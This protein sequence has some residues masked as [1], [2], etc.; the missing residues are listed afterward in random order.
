[1]EALVSIN[2]VSGVVPVVA[3]AAPSGGAVSQQVQFTPALGAT[4]AAAISV[5]TSAGTAT[6]L[7]AGAT[8][9]L[10]VADTATV[11]IAFLSGP[12]TTGVTFATSVRVPTGDA[13][14]T[15]TIPSG[16]THIAA[17]CASGTAT[18]TIAGGVGA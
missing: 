14:V 1:M 15:F 11:G 8:Q 4:P 5:S 7:P 3:S 18:L 10:C 13:G 17:I 9:L 16:A 2:G 6:A 12:V